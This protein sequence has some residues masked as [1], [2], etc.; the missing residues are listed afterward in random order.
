[1]K[2]IKVKQ[3]KDKYTPPGDDYDLI[4][5]DAFFAATKADLLKVASVIVKFFKKKKKK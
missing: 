3:F 5:G 2:I 1:M 4:C